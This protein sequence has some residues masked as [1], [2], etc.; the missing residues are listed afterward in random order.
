MFDDLGSF[1]ED[2]LVFCTVFLSGGLS[3]VFL[4]SDWGYGFGEEAHKDELPIL[5]RVRDVN[6]TCHC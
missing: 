2:W 3:D 1:Q 5:S 6:M 4:M